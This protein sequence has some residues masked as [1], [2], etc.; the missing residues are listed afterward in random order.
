MARF[1]DGASIR[2]IA[3]E[4][5]I[6]TQTISR[7]VKDEGL[8]PMLVAAQR[9]TSRKAHGLRRYVAG[10]DVESIAAEANVEPATV[11][12]WLAD[13]GIERRESILARVEADA[14]RAD[15]VGR[16]EAGESANSIALSTGLARSKVSA[17][18]R[19]A[20]LEVRRNGVERSTKRQVVDSYVQ[21][22]SVANIVDHFGVAAIS[23]RRWIREAGHDVR[24][25]DLYGTHGYDSAT[26]AHAIQRRLNRDT[27]V[28][29]ARDIGAHPSTVADWCHG[30]HP[31]DPARIAP[32]FYEPDTKP[33]R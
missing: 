23:V 28:D 30:V 9:N 18:V 16:Y 33:R 22:A 14:A 29:I 17:W 13:A 20:G 15:A 2:T 5:G 7:W 4:S 19:D 21:G 11:E 27:Y 31:V 12:L 6:S 26:R 3:A 32:N 10:D 25:E 24:A 8:D 1:V